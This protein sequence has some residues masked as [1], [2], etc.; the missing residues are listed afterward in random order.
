MRINPASTKLYIYLEGGGACFNAA[1]CTISLASFGATDFAGWAS[2]VGLTGI[3]DP[4][5]AANPVQDWN[6]IY[7]PYCSADVHVGDAT[8]VNVNGGGPTDQTFIGYENVGYDLG[9]IVPT[10]PQ[11]TQ[12]LLTGISAGGFGAAYNYDRANSAAFCPPPVALIDDSG[13]PMSDGYLAPC[14]A[15]AVAIAL[16]PRRHAARG[17]H[18]RHR[19]RRRHREL[20]DLP[21]A[22]LAEQPQ[23]ADLVDPGRR[24]HRLLRLRRRQ[25]H[26]IDPAL[27]RRV[28]RGAH[29][30][31]AEL[32]VERRRLG[33]VLHR[34]LSS[35]PGCSG[36]AST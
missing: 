34:Q 24:D 10:F 19:G 29:G 17:L 14:S 18:V 1:T 26:G 20:R 22:A 33:H 4:T 12:V 30:P 15:G 3:F 16:E 7:V 23:G 8:G 21:L 31:P 2:T 5:N 32:P 28:H 25:L 36:R 13:P 35:T 9:R 27:G 11:V 6:A